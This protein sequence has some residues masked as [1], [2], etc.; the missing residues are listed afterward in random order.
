MKATALIIRQKKMIEGAE[1]LIDAAE[2][3][4]RFILFCL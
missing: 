4:K 3:S 2:I 1:L